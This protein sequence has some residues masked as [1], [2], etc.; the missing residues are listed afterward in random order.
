MVAKNKDYK[1]LSSVKLPS[2]SEWTLTNTLP[3]RILF[4]KAGKDKRP[5]FLLPYSDN[6][7]KII[8]NSPH[9]RSLFHLLKAPWKGWSKSQLV[10]A[11][12]IFAVF[13][14][15]LAE[16]QQVEAAV[17][18]PKQFRLRPRAPPRNAIGQRPSLSIGESSI[19]SKSLEWAADHASLSIPLPCGIP[20]GSIGDG[21]LVHRFRDSTNKGTLHPTNIRYGGIEVC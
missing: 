16:I 17:K 9:M 11:G 7:R 3:F 13:L 12:G 2:G 8:D 5:D 18:S 4:V 19:S 15:R 14:C 21:G 6:A 20:A 1:P 10:E